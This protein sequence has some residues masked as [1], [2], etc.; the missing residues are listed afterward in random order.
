MTTVYMDGVF[1]LFH[2]GHLESIQQC[3]LLGS[4][5]IIGVVGDHDAKNYKRAPI[6]PQ[7]YRAS[8][9]QHIKGVEQVICPCP[10]KLTEKFIRDNQ[11]DLVVHGF[12][13]PE[14]ETKQHEFFKVPKQLGIFRTI[15]YSSKA[16]TT[17]IIKKINESST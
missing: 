14:D 5:V 16:N 15:K 1:D 12:S 8:I 2:I 11:I 6:I 3:C 7:N 17:E 13:N 4:K 9:I 10:L